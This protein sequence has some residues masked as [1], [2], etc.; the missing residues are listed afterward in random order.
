[1]ARQGI[2]FAQFSDQKFWMQC[3]QE[4]FGSML[5][6]LLASSSD[7][8]WSVGVT[9]VVLQQVLENSHLFPLITMYRIFH[10]EHLDPVKGVFW[11]LLQIFGAYVAGH[12]GGALGISVDKVAGFGIDNVKGGFHML[13]TMCFFLH[14]WCFTSDKETSICKPFMVM[15]TFAICGWFNS[16]SMNM[17]WMFADAANIGNSWVMLVWTVVA[18][19]LTWVKFRFVM[20]KD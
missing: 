14:V 8:A 7:S 17:A 20:T 19:I 16:N 11:V 9:Y 3:M 2:D 4:F 1:M 6:I 12:L 10:G 13:I 5:W 15:F 18:A